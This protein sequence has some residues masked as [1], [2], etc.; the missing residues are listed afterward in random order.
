MHPSTSSRHTGQS[1]A[2]HAIPGPQ[3]VLSATAQQ[4]SPATAQT[5]SNWHEPLS[6]ILWQGSESEARKR[7]PQ[8]MSPPWKVML[9][10]DGSVTRHL[11]LLTDLPVQV[12]CLEMRNVGSSTEG[13]PPGVEAI[14]GPRTQRQVLL[15]LPDLEK[16]SKGAMVY[17]CSWW[18]AAHVSEYLKDSSRPIW[19]SLSQGRTELYRDIQQV[20]C[21]HSDYLEEAFQ[22]RGPFWGR[23]YVFWHNGK[24]L[25][26]IYEVFSTALEQYLG[27]CGHQ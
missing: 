11:Q 5:P 8:G 2:T 22:T 3:H 13:L 19:E 14:P 7:L 15:R 23:H 20:Y 1:I 12:D 9:L 26:L 24:P 6:T 16:G 4:P 27:P 21:G 18:D 10:S 17:A 25:T